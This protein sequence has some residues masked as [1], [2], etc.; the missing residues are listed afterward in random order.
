MP[1][2]K[3]YKRH[4]EKVIGFVSYRLVSRSRLG[5]A[6]QEFIGV[7][8]VPLTVVPN[9]IAAVVGPAQVIVAGVVALKLK[10]AV[11]GGPAPRIE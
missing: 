5:Q 10:P 3:E 1:V 6:H 8:N 9:V 4:S 2:L 7:T 11:G